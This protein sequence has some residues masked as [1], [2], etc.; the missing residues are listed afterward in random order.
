MSS[1]VVSGE[2]I[3]RRILPSARSF[4]ISR[5]KASMM[6]SRNMISMPGMI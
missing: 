3:M 4:W 2:N 1:R 5:M 6:N